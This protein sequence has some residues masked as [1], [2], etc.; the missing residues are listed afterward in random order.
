MKS[1][2]LIAICVAVCVD[3]WAY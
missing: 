3:L 2:S 1:S